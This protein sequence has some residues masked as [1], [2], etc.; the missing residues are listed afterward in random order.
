MGAC[1]V[2]YLELRVPLYSVFVMY[3]VC[4]V[5]MEMRACIDR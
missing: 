4:S 1:G 3:F 5:E 2:G